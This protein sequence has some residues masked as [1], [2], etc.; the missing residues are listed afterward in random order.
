MHWNR[1]RAAGLLSGIMLNVLPVVSSG[2]SEGLTWVWLC[3]AAFCC[4]HAF[5]LLM[6]ACRA[7]SRA[8]WFTSAALHRQ[9]AAEHQMPS[10]HHLHASLCVWDDKSV[11]LL[12]IRAI[13]RWWCVLC[14]HYT[15]I[16]AEA[17]LVSTDKVHVRA[18]CGK[19][20]VIKEQWKREGYNMTESV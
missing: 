20:E 13:S 17:S 12:H 11:I 3:A 9:N 14:C 19:D 1:L 7:S 15:N 10:T 2:V 8:H 18:Q 5:W 6:S 16:R 4:C